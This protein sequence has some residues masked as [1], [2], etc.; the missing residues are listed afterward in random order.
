M[1]WCVV[2]A[3]QSRAGLYASYA[4]QHFGRA[5]EEPSD[6][7][8]NNLTNQAARVAISHWLDQAG[9][10]KGAKHRKACFETADRI[11][12][13]VG[14]SWPQIVGQQAAADTARVGR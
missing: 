2:S 11:R 3:R 6:C 7:N 14:M 4:D 5:W 12:E 10:V 13:A 1:G 9:Q 8:L